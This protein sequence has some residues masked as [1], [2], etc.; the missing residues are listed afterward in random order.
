MAASLPSHRDVE[1]DAEP[2]GQL[3]CDGMIHRFPRP[4]YAGP[5]AGPSWVQNA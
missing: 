1:L 4:S 2:H 3:E 5:G